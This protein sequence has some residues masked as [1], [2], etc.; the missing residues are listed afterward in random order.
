[1]QAG[2]TGKKMQ[3]TEEMEEMEESRDKEKEK[4]EAGQHT[5]GDGE[6]RTCAAADAAREGTE[7]LLPNA[8]EIAELRAVY[9]DAEPERDMA[10]PVFGGL[11]RGEIRP[12]LRQVYE[13][14][15]HDRLT[16]AAVGDAVSEALAK[17][18]PAAAAAA[19]ASAAEAA[20]KEAEERLLEDIRLQGIRPVEN[21]VGTP[22]AVASHPAVDRLT[23]AERAQLARRAEHGERIRL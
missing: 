22:A 5:A 3:E 21:G 8:A 4:R 11:V 6:E 16:E 9:P 10:D 7:S 18:I 19:S 12:T 17:E 20:A 14:F 13:M 15:H 1:M 2:E 23:R